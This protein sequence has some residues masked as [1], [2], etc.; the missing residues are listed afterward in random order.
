[1]RSLIVGIAFDFSCFVCQARER[2]HGLRQ[3]DRTVGGQARET[4]ERRSGGVGY[5]E[6]CKHRWGLQSI[7]CCEMGSDEESGLLVD[8]LT[9]G[10]N[11]GRVE[12]NDR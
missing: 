9:L 2:G 3:G 4:Q 10:Q 7:Y 12:E 11:G 1:M 8:S 5:Q 6:C